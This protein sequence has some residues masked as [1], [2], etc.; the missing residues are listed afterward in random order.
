MIPAIIP[1]G[2]RPS[3]AEGLSAGGM[4]FPSIEPPIRI[5]WWTYDY[6]KE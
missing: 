1:P 6:R 5:T 4:A 2:G 3:A